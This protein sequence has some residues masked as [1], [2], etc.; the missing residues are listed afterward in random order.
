MGKSIVVTEVPYQTSVDAIAGKLAEVVDAGTVRGIKDIRN[1]SGQGQTRLVIEL[2]PDTDPDIV[3]NNLFKHTPA[4]VSFAMNMVALVDGV[5]HTLGVIDILSHWIE[6]QVQVLTRRS[7]FRLNKA[8]ARLHIVEG[9]HKAIDMID[10][11]IRTIR[12][13]TI[14]PT[15]ATGS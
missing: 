10:A 15:P 12:P 11:V 3:L 13:R 2:R 14:D 6:H 4:Q 9:L 5:P 7:Q 1:E 8:K